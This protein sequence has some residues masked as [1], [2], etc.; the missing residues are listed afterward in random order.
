M[1]INLKKF[2][3]IKR[4]MEIITNINSMVVIDNNMRKSRV[5]VKV[6]RKWNVSKDD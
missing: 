6:D 4:K 3:K 1:F 2:N 5:M